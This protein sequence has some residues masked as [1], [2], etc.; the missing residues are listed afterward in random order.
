[1][2]K[3]CKFLAL[4]SALAPTSSIVKLSF[5]PLRLGKVVVIPGRSSPLIRPIINKPAAKRAPVLPAEKIASA[6]P[7]FTAWA[8]KTIDEFFLRRTALTGSSSIV[9]TSSVWTTLTFLKSSM[10]LAISSFFPYKINS[11]SGRAF[12]ASLTPLT[13]SSGALSPPIASTAI[14]I[15]LLL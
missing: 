15:T 1:M 13:I 9:I 8:A 3:S 14:F 7:F 11:T 10:Y 2:A 5:S 4:L 12:L 6:S